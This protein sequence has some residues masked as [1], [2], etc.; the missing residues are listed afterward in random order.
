MFEE[1]IFTGLPPYKVAIVIQVAGIRI[2]LY[3]L[4]CFFK[5][6]INVMIDEYFS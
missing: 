6:A 1:S 4:R 5:G 3:L 2:L